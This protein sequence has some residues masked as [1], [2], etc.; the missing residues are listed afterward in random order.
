MGSIVTDIKII[1]V[2]RNFEMYDRLVRNNDFN[3]GAEFVVFDNNLENL[4]ISQ[5]YNSFLDNYDYSQETW[6]VFCHEDWEIKEDLASRLNDLDKGCLYGP[7]GAPFA[8]K[9]L[10]SSVAWG[11]IEQSDKKGTQLQRCGRCNDQLPEVG[12]FDCQCLIVHSSLIQKHHLRFD[13]NLYFDLYVED[14]CINARE[15]YNIS[16][17][18]LQLN[19][20]HWSLGNAG[21]RFYEK[22]DYLRGKYKNARYFYISTVG[23]S[24]ITKGV[25]LDKYKILGKAIYLSKYIFQ[26]KKT[27][28]NNLIIKVFRIPIFYFSLVD[29]K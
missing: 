22:L 13:E 2:V 1:S 27:K 9:A 17:K 23:C 15:N 21:E 19:C 26:I 3:Q 14:F 6:F 18:V 10:V 28:S 25:R 29:N 11:Q 5:R 7:I 4:G 24:K 12:T 20:H 16:S 8:K